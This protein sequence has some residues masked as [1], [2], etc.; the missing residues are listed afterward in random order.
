MNTSTLQLNGE[1]FL[2]R[3]QAMQ[4]FGISGVTLWNWVKKGIIRQH[5]IGKH[6][7]FIETELAEDIK[8]SG[9]VSK[10]AV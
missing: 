9:A 7:Y 5:H 4:L 3:E 1:N 10:G 6:V 2:T 8:K